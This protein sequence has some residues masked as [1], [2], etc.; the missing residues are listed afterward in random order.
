MVGG[1]EGMAHLLIVRGTPSEK[2]GEE[3]AQEPVIFGGL[4]FLAV[5]RVLERGISDGPFL[6]DS[7]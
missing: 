2:H 3:T 1:E 7:F 6:A 5:P 4:V